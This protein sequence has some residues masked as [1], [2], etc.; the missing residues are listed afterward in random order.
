MSLN[1][2]ASC[3]KPFGTLPDG[4]VVNLYI[5]ANGKGMEVSVINFGGIIQSLRVP[6]KKGNIEDVVLG[7]DSLEPYFQ[8]AP[9][10]GAIIGRYGN[11]IAKGMF[12]LE[13]KEYTLP[14]NNGPNHLHGGTI[15]F[16]KVFWNI[17]QKDSSLLLTYTSADGE[18]GYPGT[19]ACTVEY[20]LT[21]DNE[22]KV[23]YTATTDKTTIVN[24]TQHSYFNLAGQKSTTILDHGLS[25]EADAFLPVNEYL[26]PTG[27][28]RKV[29]NTPFDFTTPTRVG[30]RI[31]STDEQLARAGGYDHCWIINKEGLRKAAAVWEPSSGRTLEVFT[32]E[33]GIQLYT[34]NFLDGTLAGKE[35]SM[36]H[37][38][39]GLCLETQHFPD[40][41]NQHNFP[42]VV[43]RPHETY[44]STTIFKF[45]VTHT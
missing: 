11:R 42:N 35:G 44:Q 41:P 7:F 26:I 34:G 13:R 16:D 5:L 3:V 4:K 23:H 37:R 36:L 30:D 22:L 8:N 6:D 24:L 19:L 12:M 32:N 25:I 29:K 39:S 2:N 21:D 10:L 20:I 40:S 31:D 43:L 18:Q 33:P 27:E 38:R 28:Y 1:N 45:G 14:V 9:Y 17:E 15:G